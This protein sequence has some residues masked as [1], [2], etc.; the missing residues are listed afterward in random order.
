[1]PVD[2]APYR[3]LLYL[4]GILGLLADPVAGETAG[5]VPQPAAVRSAEEIPEVSAKLLEVRS[6]EAIPEED[7]AEMEEA[8]A[9][10]VDLNTQLRGLNAREAG[11]VEKIVR[12]LMFRCWRLRRT[13]PPPMDVRSDAWRE[14]SDDVR[15]AY[16]RAR[17]IRESRDRTAVRP[18]EARAPA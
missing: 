5:K 14:L 18:R 17:D 10:I 6:A 4:D 16:E 11:K 8:V 7:I 9:E 13:L 1:M 3:V 2:R 15:R 12:S